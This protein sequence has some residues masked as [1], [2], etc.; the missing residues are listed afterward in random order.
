VIS[1]PR[2]PFHDPKPPRT[3]DKFHKLTKVTLLAL[4]FAL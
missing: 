2:A 1:S 3:Y 4:R